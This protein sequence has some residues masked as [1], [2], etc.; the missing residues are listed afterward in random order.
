MGRCGMKPGKQPVGVCAE[1][2]LLDRRPP[3]RVADGSF[4]KTL[5]VPGK[6][7]N[8]FILIAKIEADTEV[9]FETRPFESYHEVTASRMSCRT[10][11]VRAE[12]GEVNAESLNIAFKDPATMRTRVPRILASGAAAV[13]SSD[14]ELLPSELKG[15]EIFGHE[16]RRV[17]NIDATGLQEVFF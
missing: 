14:S 3:F 13:D 7:K 4:E 2:P 12:G 11:A 6:I 10:A 8:I 16:T 9:G 17:D 1:K 5:I 15:F